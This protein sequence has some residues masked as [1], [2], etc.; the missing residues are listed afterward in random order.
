MNRDSVSSFIFHR[1]ALES[2]LIAGC[3]IPGGRRVAFSLELLKVFTRVTSHFS[4]KKAG[5]GLQRK[6][7]WLRG[8]QF[9]NRVM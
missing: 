7:Q 4:G 5:P 3:Q 1:I 2:F 6:L 9:R 8:N